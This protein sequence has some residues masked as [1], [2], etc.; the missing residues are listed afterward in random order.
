MRSNDVK[1]FKKFLNNSECDILNEWVHSNKEN[2]FF[3]TSKNSIS[4][5]RKTTRNSIEFNFNY[6]DVIY[7]KYSL[8]KRILNIEDYIFHRNGKEGIVCSISDY[9]SEL[10]EHKDP[11]ILGCESYH[12]LIKTS[13]DNTGGD[14]I[15]NGIEYK[16]ECGDCICFF[17]SI[18]EHKLTPYF[19]K[20]L[21]ITWFY[22]AQIP[23]E[24]IE[25]V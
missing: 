6:P 8:L 24:I 1:I 2:A 19:G 10:N 5:N 15:V 4:K 7:K 20:D 9:D 12:L 25:Y 14:L 22:S 13:K 3:K 21:R 16:I 18:N 23:K 11:T 17:A